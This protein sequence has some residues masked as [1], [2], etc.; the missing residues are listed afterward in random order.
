[1][2]IP[3]YLTHDIDWLNPLHGYSLL[4]WMTPKR[5]WLSF[6]QLL[7][8]DLYLRQIE[9]VIALEKASLVNSTF[10]IGATQKSY[11]RYD[12]RYTTETTQYKT[13]LGLLKNEA[14]GLHSVQRFDTGEQVALLGQQ[15]GKKIH[16][17]RSHFLKFDPAVLYPQLLK[18]GI[19]H[20][21]SIGKARYVE[22][23]LKWPTPPEG[24]T[25]IP[26]LLSDNAFFFQP[27]PVVFDE[28]QKG[29]DDAVKRNQAFSIL[30]HPENTLLKPEL[31]EYYERILQLCKTYPFNFTTT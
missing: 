25:L 20:D 13:L 10:F 4:K 12:I 28:L 26:T 8:P 7:K 23:P 9:K 14:T 24:L 31:M 17:H 30:L 21:F 1:M 19:T 15:T 2:S 27:S 3:V 29:L 6:G 5:Q 22:L 11:G 16:G 18:A